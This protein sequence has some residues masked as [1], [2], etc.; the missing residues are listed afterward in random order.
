MRVLLRIT[1]AAVLYMVVEALAPLVVFGAF[2]NGMS[3]FAALGIAGTIRILFL[4]VLGPFAAIQLLRLRS[5]GRY[6]AAVL[7]LYVVAFEA[8]QLLVPRPYE[9]AHDQML[10]R[11]IVGLAVAV[12]VLLPASRRACEPD[13]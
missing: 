1:A 10:K 8:W 9:V 6:A 2:A 13:A 4:V 12:V 5:S 7:G 3:A 11:L